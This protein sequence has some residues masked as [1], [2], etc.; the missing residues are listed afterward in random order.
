MPAR[1]TTFDPTASWSK[2]P[3]GAVPDAQRIA[4]AMLDDVQT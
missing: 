2:D 4:T 1:T 3:D